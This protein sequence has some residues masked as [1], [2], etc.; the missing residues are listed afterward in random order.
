MKTRVALAVAIAFAAGVASSS[1][2]LLTNGSF[3]TGDLTGW[4]E[5]VNGTLVYDASG[6]PGVGAQDGSFALRID[7]NND[8]GVVEQGSF[9]V[10][11]AIP[12]SPGDEFN[13]SGWMLT[14]DDL[15]NGGFVSGILKIV[16]ED[17]AGNDLIPASVSIGLLNTTNPG[18]EGVPFLDSTI[19]LNTW[20]FSET[21]AVAP[22]NTEWGRTRRGPLRVR[23][24]STASVP[25]WPV[26]AT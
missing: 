26:R 21:Q 16:F 20:V 6:A 23:G 22:A 18:A 12:A 25:L 15:T 3:E 17:A 1:A 10:G 14:E 8:V 2:N 13:L 5:T 9:D 24:T 19:P 11:P 7:A 4:N